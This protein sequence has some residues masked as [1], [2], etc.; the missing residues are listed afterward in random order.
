M[1]DDQLNK[2]ITRLTDRLDVVYRLYI[3]KIAAQIRKVG[4]LNQSSINRLVIMAD[5][6]ADVMEVT[7]ALH[8][9]TGLNTKEVFQIYQTALNDTY[10][11]KRFQVYL[12][13][14]PE[15][16]LT[17]DQKI[18]IA[19]TAQLVSLQTADTFQNLSN[20]TIVSEAY[21]NAVDTAILAVSS[22]LTDYRSATRELVQQLGYNGL[23]VYYPSGYHRRLD[24]AVRQNVIDGVR[25]IA[26]NA[27]LAMGDALGFDAV[28]LTAHMHAAPDHE[29]VQGRVF[30]RT[31]FDKMQNGEDFE[32]TDGNHYSGFPRAIGMWNCMHIAMGFSTQFSKRR[33][34]PEQLADWA[35]RNKQGCTI[36]N[37]H[38]TTYEAQQYMRRLETQIRRQK[39]IANA[40]REVNDDALR[41]KAQVRINALT[42]QYQAVSEASGLK[43]KNDRLTVEGFR[44]VKV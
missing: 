37:K 41:R 14:H 5:M 42:R 25:E 33:Y 2:A 30:L 13:Q 39:D 26:Q 23:Q 19:R 34:S 20:T 29:P 18:Q 1:T 38:Y 15:R 43:T 44:A 10:T 11:D 9:A 6:G 4:E 31:E 28:E 8:K 17:Q 7:Q 12:Q 22:G 36:G 3:K 21:Q 35:A 24:T 32:D 27:S 40:A 16:A